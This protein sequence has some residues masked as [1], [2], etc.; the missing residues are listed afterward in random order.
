MPHPTTKHIWVSQILSYLGIIL[1][2]LWALQNLQIH[3]M[4]FLLFRKYWETKTC[5][6]YCNHTY[7]FTYNF[8]TYDLGILFICFKND[9]EQEKH[10]FN[11]SF[12][13]CLL[14][15]TWFVT[16]GFLEIGFFFLQG[17][18]IIWWFIFWEK[19]KLCKPILQC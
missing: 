11:L 10:I 2:K 13:Q 19:L 4:V 5:I 16:L 3:N 8:S 7:Y 14:C 17:K 9:Y 12:T 6:L 18:C 15:F 1:C